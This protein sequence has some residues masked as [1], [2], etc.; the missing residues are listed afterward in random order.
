MPS[1][2]PDPVDERHSTESR[3]TWSSS[4]LPCRGRAPEQRFRE[5]LAGWRFRESLARL[6]KPFVELVFTFGRGSE[7]SR[8]PRDAALHHADRLRSAR[9]STSI[10][11]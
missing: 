7:W 5:D 2:P 3:V 8:S 4:P 6:R 9:I 11:D 10:E 1:T